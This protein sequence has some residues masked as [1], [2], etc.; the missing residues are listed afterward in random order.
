MVVTEG[1]RVSLVMILKNVCGSVCGIFPEEM[2]FISYSK[3][4]RE[5]IQSMLGEDAKFCLLK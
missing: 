5:Y 1:N 3:H 4:I 2:A